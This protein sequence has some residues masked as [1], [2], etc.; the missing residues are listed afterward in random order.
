MSNIFFLLIVSPKNSVIT[1][2]IENAVFVNENATF[3]CTAMGG[4][5]NTYKWTHINTGQTVGNEFEL[6]IASTVASN[7]GSYRC[8]AKNNA[9]SDDSTSILN[10]S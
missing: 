3:N 4:P 2:P 8:V 10:G 1:E 6:K 9:G 5:D 7:G